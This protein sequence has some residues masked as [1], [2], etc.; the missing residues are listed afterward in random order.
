[1]NN[2]LEALLARKDLTGVD[3]D[4]QDVSGVSF[5]EKTLA[6]AC[7]DDAVAVKTDFQGCDLGFS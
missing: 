4:S 1:M 7:F 2:D 5:A 6:G 3:F